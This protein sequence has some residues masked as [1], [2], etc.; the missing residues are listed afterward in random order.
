[1]IDGGHILRHLAMRVGD[2]SLRVSFLLQNVGIKI[3]VKILRTRNLVEMTRWTPK[4][5][6]KTTKR[7][8]Q[9]KL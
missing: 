2:C 7:M 8:S 3:S 5:K 4:L 1:M 9:V 6:S